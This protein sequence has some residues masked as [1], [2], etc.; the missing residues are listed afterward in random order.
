MKTII[1]FLTG[2]IFL[3]PACD[4]VPVSIPSAPDPGGQV[5]PQNV[6][7]EEYT[8]VRCQNCPAGA[9]LLEELKRIHGDRLIILSI[10]GGFFAQP[11]NAEN[12]FRLDNAFGAEL[13]RLFNEPLGYPSAMISRKI[14][15]GQ[16]SRFLGGGFWAGYV[17]EELDQEP[18]IGLELEILPD[19]DPLA[20]KVKVHVRA[21]EVQSQV[22]SL[23][24]ALT[25][26]NIRDAQ[27]T[28]TGVDTNY[29]HRHVLRSFL[30]AISGDPAG[31]LPTNVKKTFEYSTT[32]SGNWKTGDL[33]LIAFIHEP[34]PSFRVVQAAE[35]KI[36]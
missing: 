13:I 17:A 23:S 16:S 15:D 26:T 21:L 6:L 8:G 34:S 35:A 18:I 33:S 1:L 11:T 9:Q 28:P 25:E 32:L 30:S 31:I 14:F 2:L 19:P 29:V 36:D 24:V 10:H 7:I 4:E 3:L 5:Y 12:K 20:L 27:L 22:L